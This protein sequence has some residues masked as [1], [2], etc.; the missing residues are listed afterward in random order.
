VTYP[1]QKVNGVLVSGF[2]TPEGKKDFIYP[3]FLVREIEERFGEYPLFTKTPPYSA[4]LSLTNFNKFIR[5]LFEILAYKFKVAHYLLDNY[6]FDF[7]MIHIWGTDKI[8]HELWNLIDEKHRQF[9]KNMSKKC[10]ERIFNYFEVLDFEISR[11]V[12][13]VHEGVSLF[14]VSDHGFGPIHKL[15]N[16]NTWL[17]KEGYIKIK[18]RFFSLLRYILWKLGLTPEFIYKNIFRRLLRLKWAYTP[19]SP[20]DA[21]KYQ[22]ENKN[23]FFL[24]LDDIDWPKSKAYSKAGSFGTIFINR[25]CREITSSID[26][27]KE[28][29][30]IRKEIASKLKNLTDVKDN[31][32]I[33]SN[34]YF[35]EDI[36]RGRYLDSAPDI[37]FYAQESGYLSGAILGFGS[38]KAILDNIISS[39]HHRMD[40]IFIAKGKDII[41]GKEIR[42]AHLI[43]ITPTI[44]YLM[45]LGIPRDMDGK[46]LESIFTNSFLK[47]QKP[48]YID[49]PLPEEDKYGSLNEGD[50]ADIVKKLKNLRY[51]T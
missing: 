29:Q 46:V 14:I 5:E 51:I 32:K 43:D 50:K 4:N 49:D 16:L 42:D 3:Q 9:N 20:Y 22:V 33:E 12:E 47:K 7:F 17:L 15:I 39:G 24:S 40:G 35:K 27:E 21:I 37:V 2:L 13:R 10:I 36:Y 1:P 30:K 34:L 11:L 31:S 18:K 19:K 23:K 38:N 41:S 8:Q 6:D 44:L 25:A 45:D 48:R 26:P 28:Y